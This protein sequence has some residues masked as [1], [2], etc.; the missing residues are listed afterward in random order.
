MF[1]SSL[2]GL[3]TF[4]NREPRHKWLGYSQ[5]K[6]FC[7]ALASALAFFKFKSGWWSGS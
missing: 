7:A 3:M 5:S 2:T 4:P 6:S 1:L